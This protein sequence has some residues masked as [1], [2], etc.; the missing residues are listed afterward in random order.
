MKITGY[1]TIF[2]V[3]ILTVYAMEYIKKRHR[4]YVKQAN[5][6]SMLLS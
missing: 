5:G 4:N 2:I 1:D 3:N 6:S